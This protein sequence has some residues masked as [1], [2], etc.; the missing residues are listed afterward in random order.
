MGT[1]VRV[2]IGLVALAACGDNLGVRG[3]GDGGGPDGKNVD[4]K[5]VDSSGSTDG[6]SSGIDAP[7]V[8]TIAPTIASVS[9]VDGAGSV[10]LHDRFSVTF[11]ERIAPASVT[12]QS[13]RLLDPADQNLSGEVQVSSDG[14]VAYV[15]AT[16]SSAMIGQLRLVVGTGITDVAGNALASSATYAWTLAPWAK[17]AGGVNV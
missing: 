14:L 2:V 13:L 1:R 5:T 7:P 11:S 12:P 16:D 3:P 10:W 4:G 9:P 8:D 17:L 6:T 15:R